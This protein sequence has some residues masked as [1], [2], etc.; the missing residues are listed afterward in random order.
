VFVSIPAVHPPREAPIAMATGY[1]AP[2]L[3]RIAL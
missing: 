1:D 2:G 3:T